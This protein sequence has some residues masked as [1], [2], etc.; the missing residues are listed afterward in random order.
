MLMEQ[1]TGYE[2]I[3]TE[4]CTAGFQ[5]GSKSMLVEKNG[6]F[7]IIVMKPLA[8]QIQKQL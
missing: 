1:N 4:M 8:I 7:H 3:Y 2:N 6:L 5:Q